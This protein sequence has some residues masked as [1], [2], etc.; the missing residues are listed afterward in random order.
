MSPSTPKITAIVPIRNRS[1]V[2]LENCLRSLRWQE[3]DGVVP[4]ALGDHLEIVLSDFGSTS[5]HREDVDALAARYG[6][7]IV[8][9]ETDAI[10]NRSRVLNI[11]IRAARSPLVLCTDADMLFSPNFVQSVLDA[12]AA[13]PNALV[14]ARCYDVPE[15][16]PEQLHEVS[17]FPALM[18]VASVRLTSGTGACQSAARAFFEAVHGYDEAYV[19]WG[20]EDNDM[21][22][23]ALLH[24]LK[25][26]W[27]HQHAV[28]MHQ[29]HPTLKKTE[30]W[31]ILKNRWRYKVT[32]RQVVKNRGGWGV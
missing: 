31:L 16:V 4:E 10:W 29:W 7:R 20:A 13:H 21:V 8:R 24:G 14:V 27:L 1:G 23:R 15:S 6:A 18:E 28:M 9:T 19:Y 11:G 22:T 25:L 30:R 32:R 12:H 17:G 26:R 5:P 3:L 2:R